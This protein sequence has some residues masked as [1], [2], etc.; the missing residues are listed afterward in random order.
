MADEKQTSTKRKRSVW[1]S[2]AVWTAGLLLAANATMLAW[3]PLASVDPESLPSAHTWAWWAAKEFTSLPKA[4]D[5]V[6]LGSSLLFQ[7]LGRLEANYHGKDIDYVRHHRVNY[8]ENALQ[9]RGLPAEICYNFSLP[10]S[11]VSDDY[12][13]MRSLL[14]GA[15][16]PK[17]AVVCISMR[18]M[19]DTQVHCI[20]TTPPFRLLTRYTDIGDIL[21]IAMPKLWQRGDYLA[22]KGFYLWGKKL[23][24]QVLLSEATKSTLA[25][26]YS[27]WFPPS[28]LAEADPARNLP[29]NLR[30]EVEYMPMR[31]NEPISWTDN[32]S[33]YKRRY[34]HANEKL[35]KDEA[36]FLAKMYDMARERGIEMVLVNA[37]LTPENHALMPS[38]AYDHYL[39]YLRKFCATRDIPLLNLDGQPQFKHEDFYDN[40]HM[41]GYGGAKM[42]DA[43]V[44]EIA[45]SPR[46]AAALRAPGDAPQQLAVSKKQAVK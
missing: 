26:T 14:H 45:T 11:M 44:E 18:D 16:K 10:G 30:S 33:E 13:V 35:F 23:D 27:Q 40:A 34:R 31:A 42:A 5:V 25:P 19:M 12:M 28:R 15:R 39:L 9:K 3:K 17:V 46:I 37:P 22:Q 4:P 36:T 41:N 21:D 24:L 7:P 32:A 2:T 29:S 1:K 8:I 38:G 43:M 6:L 20:G